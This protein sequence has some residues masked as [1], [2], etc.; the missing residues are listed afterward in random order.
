MRQGMCIYYMYI[1][2]YIDI[3][4]VHGTWHADLFDMLIFHLFGEMVIAGGKN[5]WRWE[6]SEM[7][8]GFMIYGEISD[9]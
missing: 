8:G 6:R 7:Y 3:C 4:A 5:I 9:G 1:Y 2:I